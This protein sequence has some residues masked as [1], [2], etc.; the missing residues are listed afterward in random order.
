MQN[1]K[2]SCTLI[3]SSPG[4]NEEN[5]E[6]GGFMLIQLED[7]AQPIREVQQLLQFINESPTPWHVCQSVTQQLVENG[8]KEVPENRPWRL[9]SGKGYFCT[10][11]DAS[12]FAFR[13]P[14]LPSA[15]SASLWIGAHTDS[16]CLKLKPNPARF[17]EGYHLLSIEVYG[18]AILRTWLDR[19]L[20]FGGKLV[21]KNSEGVIGSRLVEGEPIV[22]IPELAI[23]MNRD[24]NEEGKINA[25]THL[26]PV[27]GLESSDFKFRYYLESFLE[28]GEEFLDFD[29]MLYDS[30]DASLAGT[31]SEFISAP[32]LDNL[33]MV[34]AGLRT[35]LDTPSH[36]TRFQGTVFF[37]HEEVGSESRSG[38]ASDFFINMIE[39]CYLGL[40]LTRE[41]FLASLP[42][43]LLVSADMAHAVHPAF[44]EKH[45]P[46]HKPHINKGPVIKRNAKQRYATTAET[47]A[48]FKS[49]CRQCSLPVQEFVSRNDSPCGSTIGPLASAASGMPTVDVGNPMLAMHSIRELSGSVDHEAIIR[50]FRTAFNEGAAE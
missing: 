6:Q 3:Q 20:H 17:H 22:R 2:K 28:P 23:H 48:R 35:L 7:S 41:M 43:S 42:D 19:D 37:N 38:A 34:H 21:F 33:A 16:P 46:S 9:E 39:R 49:W 18:G 8:F 14:E 5:G 11:D 4:D 31:H 10:R 29:L 36:A 50:V 45:D 1:K 24:V 47:A 32:R 12:V 13:T 30:Q 44:T 40:G 26:V 25:Q 15:Q 27:L